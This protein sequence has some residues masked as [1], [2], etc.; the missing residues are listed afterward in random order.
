[1]TLREILRILKTKFEDEQQI[2]VDNDMFG[3]ANEYTLFEFDVMCL[4]SFD[5]E[6]DSVIGYICWSSPDLGTLAIVRDRF[7]EAEVLRVIE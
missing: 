6:L 5:D 4:C 1:M 7:T 3:P 2:V